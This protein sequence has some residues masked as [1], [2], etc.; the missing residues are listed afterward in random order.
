ME[1]IGGMEADSYAQV[2]QKGLDS[3]QLD[4]RGKALPSKQCRNSN[5]MDD[6]NQHQAVMDS[7][8][9]N[10]ILTG[11]GSDGKEDEYLFD[12]LADYHIEL[13]PHSKRLCTI[14]LCQKGRTNSNLFIG[15]Y[16]LN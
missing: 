9:E 16:E 11:L 10:E 1:K 8:D 7:D 5:T 6:D 12:P 15:I 14:A 3:L 4:K 13:S 2:L